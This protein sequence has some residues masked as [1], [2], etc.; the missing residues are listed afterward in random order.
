MPAAPSPAASAVPVAPALLSA[1]AFAERQPWSD[2]A[3]AWRALGRRWQIDIATA[4]PCRSI[5][6]L[7][8]A[9]YRNATSLAVL[10]Q[11]DRPV[12]LSLRASPGAAPAWALLTALDGEQASL[13]LAD[14]AATV[15]LATLASQWRGDFATLWRRPPGHTGAGPADLQGALGPWVRERLV[16]FQGDALPAT[17]SL[18]ERIRV[19]QL[20]QG[21]DPD[22]LAGPMTLM[23]LNRV[24]GESEPRLSGG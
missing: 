17:A 18:R 13:Q 19:F 12:L 14:G 10:R 5:E 15:S 21:L 8:L 24:A 23:Q 9:C 3:E 1:A 7:G 20:A 11:L 6:T 16:A 4:E 2:E 22:G